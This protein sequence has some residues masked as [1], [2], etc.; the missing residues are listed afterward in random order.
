ML[1]SR[2][3]EFTTH[4]P[5]L[6][7]NQNKFPRNLKLV[8]STLTLNLCYMT[9]I[10]G[11]QQIENGN[12]VALHNSDNRDSSNGHIATTADNVISDN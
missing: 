7:G 4:S 9:M 12:I 8:F 2:G 10:P 6:Y 11:I 5:T 3:Q 1:E